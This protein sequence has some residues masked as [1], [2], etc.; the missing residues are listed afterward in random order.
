MDYAQALADSVKNFQDRTLMPLR[1]A[2]SRIVDILPVCLLIFSVLAS[3]PKLSGQGPAPQ[4]PTP[5]APAA[6]SQSYAII[7]SSIGG[8]PE[9]EKIIDGW[10]K[11]L[12]STLSASGMTKDHL[13]WLAGKKQEGAFADC[14]KSEVAKLFTSLAAKVRPQDTVALYLIGHGS[15]DEYDYRFNMPGIDLTS[16]ELAG[17]MDQLKA[18]RQL[19]VNMTS[20]S[21]GSIADFRRKGRVLLSSTT[22][23]QERNFSVF[24]RYFVAGVQDSAADADKNEVISALEAFRYATREV[25][26]YYENAKRLATEHPVLEDKGD[27]DGVREPNAENGQGLL[28]AALPVRRLGKASDALETPEIMQAR[29]KK[30]GVEEAIEQLKYTK[31]SMETEAYSKKLESLLLELARTQAALDQLEQA[32]GAAGR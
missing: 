14:S 16:R 27:S 13:F 9:Y 25:T 3:I 15:Y 32:A 10:G 22:A 5:P 30:R 20:S 23:G 2:Q 17:M 1:Q 8:D 28:A 29:A 24:A 12:H 26:R 21:G 31:A 19:I 6:D 4:T 11:D 18:E 7:L